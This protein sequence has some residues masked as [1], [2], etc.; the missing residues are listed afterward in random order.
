M[1]F[2]ECCLFV[3]FLSFPSGLDIGCCCCLCFNVFLELTIC[4]FV[5]FTNYLIS[6]SLLC[7]LHKHT[8]YATTMRHE[9]LVCVTSSNPPLQFWSL[10][11]LWEII[12]Y[13]K[14][15]HS[16]SR[17]NDLFWLSLELENKRKI[18]LRHTSFCADFLLQ[19]SWWERGFGS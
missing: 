12:S 8:W 1:Q 9:E 7:L 5:V 14:L 13:A 17:V 19:C 6:P 10:D 11:M 16:N 3:C 4:T 18:L 15:Q 2:P